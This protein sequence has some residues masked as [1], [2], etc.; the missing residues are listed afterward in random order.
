MPKPK[1]PPPS[2]TSA[3]KK[4]DTREVR[5]QVGEFKGHQLVSMYEWQKWQGKDAE[6]MPTRGGFTVKQEDFRKFVK[7]LVKIGKE[8]GLIPDKNAKDDEQPKK[9]KK[10]EKPDEDDDED[11]EPVV[12]K[13]KKTVKETEDDDD[14][15]DDDEPENIKKKSKK[16]VKVKKKPKPAV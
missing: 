11:Q 2:H 7:T 5:I 16:T 12:K 15:Q 10:A 8:A 9:S 4:S 1:P 6:M 13:S 14:D 3:F